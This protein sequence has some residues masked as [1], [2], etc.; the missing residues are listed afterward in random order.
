MT[1]MLHSRESRQSLTPNP[2]SKPNQ[3][4][5][6]AHPNTASPRCSDSGPLNNFAKFT[7]M[8]I[9]SI[10]TVSKQMP[11]RPTTNFEAKIVVSATYT[12]RPTVQLSF[13]EYY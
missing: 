13:H 12:S 8:L 11:T 2:N 10:Y 9:G 4:P 3:I 7:P 1:F 5:F 6:H